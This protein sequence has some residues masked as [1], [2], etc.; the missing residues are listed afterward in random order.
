VVPCNSCA[1]LLSNE[2]GS[3]RRDEADVNGKRDAAFDADRA[4]NP[5]GG[6]VR[7]GL[8]ENRRSLMHRKQESIVCRTTSCVL[9]RFDPRRSQIDIAQS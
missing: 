1:A 4:S 8:S 6:H 9:P 7:D 5:F 3:E 2:L